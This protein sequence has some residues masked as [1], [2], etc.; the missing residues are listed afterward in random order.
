M[1]VTIEDVS[2]FFA[3]PSA[4][5][6]EWLKQDIAWLKRLPLKDDRGMAMDDDQALRWLKEYGRNDIETVYKIQIVKNM[7]AHRG[8]VGSIEVFERCLKNVKRWK[9]FKRERMY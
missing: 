3:N 2:H 5:D 1:N 6:I 4:E 9:E 7:F 8:F